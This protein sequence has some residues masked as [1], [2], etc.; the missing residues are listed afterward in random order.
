MQTRTSRAHKKRMACTR[1]NP[2][3]HKHTHKHTHT[4][5]HTHTHTRTHT[6]THAQ[7]HT[8]SRWD[9]SMRPRQSWAGPRPS[10]TTTRTRPHHGG[11][12]SRTARAGS[13]A[14]DRS[15]DPRTHLER[16]RAEVHDVGGLVDAD[17]PVGTRRRLW[18]WEGHMSADT[19]AQ[20]HRQKHTTTITARP[21]GGRRRTSCRPRC[22]G[23]NL[24]SD[25]DPR[26]S[27]SDAFVRH[28]RSTTATA[29]SART[30]AHADLRKM[31]TQQCVHPL[32]LPPNHRHRQ[33][34]KHTHTHT[35]TLTHTRPHRIMPRGHTTNE[36]THEHPNT[37]SACSHNARVHTWILPDHNGLVE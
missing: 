9:R 16:P 36:T 23:A 31:G 3:A 18:W 13:R 12:R 14:R 35:H 26:A 8:P 7:T 1:S 24:M 6:R 2:H 15:R 17:E 34:H 32:S 21:R 22:R 11:P 25:T 27:H 5:T 29:S 28:G 33:T 20:T 30:R 37:R 4:N 19:H 10:R